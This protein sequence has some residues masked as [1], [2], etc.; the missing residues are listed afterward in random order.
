M[1]ENVN[2][3]FT[4]R[5]HKCGDVDA[6]LIGQEVVVYGWIAKQRDLGGRIFADLR[7]RSGLLQLAFDAEKTAPDLYHL[8]ETLRS[9]WCICARGTVLAR[10]GDMVNRDMKTGEVEVFVEDLYVLNKSELPPFHI[11]D[12]V[13]ASEDLRLT[14]RYLDLRRPKMQ[15]NL[16][17]RDSFVFAL[18]EALHKSGFLDIETPILGKSTPEGARDFLVPSRLQRGEWYALP[19]SPQLFKE[20][21]MV[22][23]CDRYYQIARCFRDED[24]RADRQPEFT[25]VDLEMSFV[26][27]D[28]VMSCVER[29]LRPAFASVGVTLPDEVEH[30]SYWDAMDTYGSDKP[31]T[32]FAMH[33][34]DVTELV[35]K[36]PFKVFSETV[37]QGGVVRAVCAK[38]AG[39]WGRSKIDKLAEVAK[40]YGAKGLVW[41][42]RKEDGSL[43]S[44]SAKFMEPSEVDAVLHACAAEKGDLVLLVA[45]TRLIADTAAG[46]LRLHLA[47]ELGIERRGH[48]FLWVVNFPMFEY[49]AEAGR[50]VAQHHPFTLPRDW[51]KFAEDPLLVGSYT[52][53]F[54]MDGCE[55]GGGGLRI[56]TADL[57]LEVLRAL[58][59]SEKD[60]R[61][62]FGFLLTALSFGAPPMGGFALGLDRVCMLCAGADSIRDVMA[63]PKTTSGSDLMMDAPAQ[64]SEA[65]LGEL[66][67][68]E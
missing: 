53:D 9:E 2:A 48:S 27:A 17:L 23:G 68:S 47:D 24:L 59:F 33:L 45:D 30:M 6:S 4:K 63:F 38:G 15:A 36:S 5:T 7:D 32:R 34:H 60:A 21:L 16:A 40:A 29:V 46:A 12:G 43:Q 57:Q 37:A 14:W 39:V 20:L 31:D 10:P 22:A 51:E 35:A 67:L 19:Q 25:Q 26:D 66:G 41:F 64:V 49:D 56:H 11:E 18:R 50:Y 1:C 44:P 62:Q 13:D 54:V 58:G 61:E 55:A 8:A 42:A 3:D 52:Y 65:Q 28:E